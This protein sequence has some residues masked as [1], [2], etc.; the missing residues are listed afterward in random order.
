MA[1]SASQQNLGL[2]EYLVAGFSQERRILLQQCQLTRRGK[3]LFIKYPIPGVAPANTFFLLND[4]EAWYSRAKALGLTLLVF[5]YGENQREILPIN[6]YDPSLSAA[7]KDLEEGAIASLVK[8]KHLLKIA[9][10]TVG[11]LV[12]VLFWQAFA[13]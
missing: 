5:D 12:E 9:K 2:L 8:A 6:L 11:A 4:G 13:R 7:F 3:A 1:D 10:T